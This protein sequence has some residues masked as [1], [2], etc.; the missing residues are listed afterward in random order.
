M[1]LRKRFKSS[2]LLN[3]AQGY[4]ISILHHVIFWTIYFLFNTLRWGSYYGD[5]F[6]SLKANLLGFPIHMA[7]CYFTIYFLL[8]K[9]IYKRKIFGFVLILLTAIFLMVFL[10]FELTYFL[11]SN[12]VWPE[13]P[14]ETSTFSFDYALVMMLNESSLSVGSPPEQPR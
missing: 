13:G 2:F 1:S 3:E 5:Y 8:P 4:Q 10:K 12:N 7:L 11:I 9:F 6:Y 14:E